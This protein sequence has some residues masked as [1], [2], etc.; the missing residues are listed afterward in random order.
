MDSKQLKAMLASYARSFSAAAIA[1][2]STGEFTTV[3]GLLAAVLSAWIP[4]LVRALNPKDPAFGIVK[5]VLP[6]IQKKLEEIAAEESKKK[7]KKKK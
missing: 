7:V 5:V 1:V 4:V 3:K 6:E 2:I